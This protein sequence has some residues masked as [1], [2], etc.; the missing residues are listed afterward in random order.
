MFIPETIYFISCTLTPF[1]KDLRLMQM[2]KVQLTKR[3]KG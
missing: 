2:I 1:V 3:L